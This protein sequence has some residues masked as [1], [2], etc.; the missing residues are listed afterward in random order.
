MNGQTNNASLMLNTP[1]NTDKIEWTCVSWFNKISNAVTNKT[2]YFFGNTVAN[3]TGRLL[4]NTVAALATVFTFIPS[5]AVDLGYATKRLYDRKVNT[6]Q[7]PTQ[8]LIPSNVSERRSNTDYPYLDEPLQYNM[9]DELYY[10]ISSQ[11]STLSVESDRSFKS[12]V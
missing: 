4:G 5:L 7:T 10:S 2:G 8:N 3:K 12:L 6:A 9:S 1:I 11:T